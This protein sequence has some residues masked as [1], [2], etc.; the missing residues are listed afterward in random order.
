MGCN[1][2]LYFFFYLF[3]LS[4]LSRIF[5]FLEMIL[6]T[7]FFQRHGLYESMTSKGPVTL[8]SDALKKI[9]NWVLDHSASQPARTTLVLVGLRSLACCQLA[10]LLPYWLTGQQFCKVY[11]KTYL[12]P[13]AAASFVEQIKSQQR[14][15]ALDCVAAIAFCI[16]DFLFPRR[17]ATSSQI[18]FGQQREFEFQQMSSMEKSCP[19][20][21]IHCSIPFNST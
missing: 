7:A 19:G 13:S 17:T 5:F 10:D 2:F 11:S 12:C 15:P 9:K 1:C 16:F 3:K 6:R 20:K 4:L 14:R 21:Q 18:A 8:G